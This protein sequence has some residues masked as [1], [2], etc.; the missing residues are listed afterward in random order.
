[1]TRPP[2]TVN[3]TYTPEQR[4]E[5]VALASTIGPLRAGKQLG[6]PPRTVAFWTHQPAASPVLAAVERDLASHLR[7]LH[8]LALAE[9]E[10][11]L[12]DPKARLGD[13]VQAV[14]VLGEQLALAEGR[15]TSHR[16]NLNVNADADPAEW[17][18]LNQE[19]QNAAAFLKQLE[20]L[21]DDELQA[22]LASSDGIDSL[23]TISSPTEETT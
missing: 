2:G 5:A 9:V 7:D 23:K 18:R 20:A 15:A 6:I 8:A 3:R 1:M 4:A 13:K 19:R 17:H 21:P 14:R 16:V 22:W 12:T 11:G 10:A